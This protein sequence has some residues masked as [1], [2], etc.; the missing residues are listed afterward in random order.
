MFIDKAKIHLKA[1]KGGDGAVAFRR[2]AHVPAG[3]PAGGDGGKGG[4][5]IFQVDEGMRTLMDFRYKR[6]YS[7]S[8]GENGKGK[9]MYGKDGENLLLNVPPGTIIR[10]KATGTIIADLTGHNDMVIVAKGGKGGKGNT[11]FKTS[12]RQAPRFATAGEHGQ[13]FTVVLEL[14]LIADVGLIGFPNVG[15]STLL[16]VVTDARPKIADY[17]FTTLTPN[18]GVVRTKHGDSFV[19]ADIPGLIEGAHEGTGLGHEFLRHIERTRLLIHVIDVAG[20]EGRDPL[21]DFEKINRE[22]HLYNEQLPDKPQVIAANKIDILGSDDNIKK[23][24]SVL[25]EQGIEVFPISAVTKQ[26]LDELLNYVS[27][28]LNELEA[29][30]EE[31]IEDKKIYKYE[32]SEDKHHFT[33]H[34]KDGVYIVKGRFIERLVNSVNLDDLDSLSYFQK[35]L[36]DRGVID[37]LKELGVSEGDSVKIYGIEFE[38]FK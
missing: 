21:E 12:T 24:K 36:E 29:L 7:A 6:H 31:T 38:Y 28:K 25:K 8:N 33:V 17:H 1:G 20:S 22:L 30:H 26:G 4:D 14:K 3:G 37:K 19:L 35:V 9:N 18:L 16:S 13:E 32:E 2:E 23:L 5:I 10:E 27:K 34:V 15:K 11:H